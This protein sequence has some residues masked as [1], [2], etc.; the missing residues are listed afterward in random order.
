[1]R[2]WSLH[3]CYLDAKGLVALWRE[4]LLAYAVL[5]NETGGYRHHPQ[6]ERFQAFGQPA[7]AVNQYL[8]AVYNEAAK[9]GYHFDAGKLGH[10][11]RCAKI[12]VTAGQLEYEWKHLQTKLRQRNPTQ[13]K[14]NQGLAT[15]QPHPLFKVTAGGIASWER[16]RSKGEL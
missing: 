8:W 6:L 9:R 5:N 2:L 7:V 15:P 13:Y 12:G 16:V 3:P 14:K 10:K 4:G 1:M 11:E